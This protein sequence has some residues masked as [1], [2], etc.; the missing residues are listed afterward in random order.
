VR[1]APW[2]VA[3]SWGTGFSH[4]QYTASHAGIGGTCGK[5][6]SWKDG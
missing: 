2:R 5:D 3:R 4:W 1:A 6:G